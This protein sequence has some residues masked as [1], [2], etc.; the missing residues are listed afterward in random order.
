M[1]PARGHDAKLRTQHHF[2]FTVLT[3][4]KLSRPC[5]SPPFYVTTPS[6]SSYQPTMDHIQLYWHLHTVR[7]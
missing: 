4:I 1:I 3:T 7:S 6:H 2:R 5:S